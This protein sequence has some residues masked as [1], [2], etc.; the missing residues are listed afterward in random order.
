MAVSRQIADL[1]HAIGQTLF[2]RNHRTVSLTRNGEIFSNA[3]SPALDAIAGALAQQRKSTSDQRLSVTVTSAF[4]TYWLM[5]RL[6]DFGASHPEIEVN[7]VVSD[8]YLDLEAEGI[9]VAVRYSPQQQNQSGWVPLMQETILPVY[10]PNYNAHTSLGS[11]Y[12]LKDERLLFLSGRYRREA[13]WEHWFAERGIV[14]T[15]ERSGV[16]VNTYINM[17][18]AAI[19]GQGI[20]L[21]GRPLVDRFLA[22]GSLK[23][24]P[25]IP[26]LKR[27]YYN[28][29]RR[30]GHE[31]A[32]V[33]CGWIEAQFES[34]N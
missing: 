9:D 20:A 32:R 26:A 12:D 25:D 8:R 31:N 33:F 5:P 2:S 18:Q 22:D 1:E 15:E 3:I 29:Y 19:E 27:G 23:T 24:I 4:A 17:L 14:P 28:L 13:R 7:L 34:A 16:S 11:E 10:S 21:A 30:S 6:V